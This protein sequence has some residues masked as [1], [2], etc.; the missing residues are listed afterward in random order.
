MILH[1]RSPGSTALGCRLNRGSPSVTHPIL[2]VCKAR[3]SQSTKA[4]SAVFAHFQVPVLNGE[5]GHDLNFV[6]ADVSPFLAGWEG[7]NPTLLG[8]YD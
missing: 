7:S 2:W 3:L 4:S 5:F 6:A 8:G 1:N